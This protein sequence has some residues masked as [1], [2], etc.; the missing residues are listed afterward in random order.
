MGLVAPQHVGSSRIRDQTHVSCIGRWIHYHWATREA[1][2]ILKVDR[3][4]TIFMVSSSSYFPPALV[5]KEIRLVPMTPGPVGLVSSSGWNS[6]KV[7]FYSLLDRIILHLRKLHVDSL[8]TACVHLAPS[9]LSTSGSVWQEHQ[10]A[11]KGT[12]DAIRP[13]CYSPRDIWSAF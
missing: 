8:T 4:L 12:Q 2:K 7:G 9:P 1:L 3:D 10:N 6:I 13:L 5:S 11:T